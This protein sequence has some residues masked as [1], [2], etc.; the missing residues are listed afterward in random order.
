MRRQGWRVYD[1]GPRHVRCPLVCLPPVSGTGDVFFRQALALSARGVRII[2][3]EAPPYWTSR[4]WCDGFRRLLDYLDVDKVHI[5][6]ASLG[7]YLA[8][9]FAEHTFSCPRVASLVLCNTF[10][11]TAVF[12][13]HETAALYWMLPSLVLKKMLMSNFEPTPS[14]DADMISAIDF[15]VE[16]LDT[17]SQ[18]E[19]ASRLTLNCVRGYVEAH[20]LA[21]IPITI[22]DVFDESALSSTVREE[23]YKCYPHAKLAHLKSGG[24]F[25]FLSRSSEV[26]LHL[27]IHLRQFDGSSCSASDHLLTSRSMS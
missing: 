23:L 15:M 1:C 4:E 17:L 22:V 26:N 10:T 13:G 20:K 5:F 14:K 27:L 24:N 6:G 12:R 7:G 2:L 19:L 16:R 18:S 25:P 3:A 21:D 9:K 8:Q 11:D